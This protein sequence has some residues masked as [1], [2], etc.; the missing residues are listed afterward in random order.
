M[1][2]LRNCPVFAKIEKYRRSGPPIMRLS[3]LPFLLLLLL[4]LLLVIE[5]LSDNHGSRE[6]R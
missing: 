2:M 3:K 6:L 5:R 1:P 4:L